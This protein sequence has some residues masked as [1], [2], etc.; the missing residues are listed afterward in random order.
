MN[1]Y[2]R[3]VLKTLGAIIVAMCLGILAAEWTVRR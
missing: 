1:T 2:D 3:I